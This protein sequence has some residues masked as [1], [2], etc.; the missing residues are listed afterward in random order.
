VLGGNLKIGK[1][2]TGVTNEI[3]VHRHQCHV[4]LASDPVGSTR[5]NEGDIVTR[6]SHVEKSEFKH[7]RASSDLILA[8]SRHLTCLG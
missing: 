3:V 1:Q 4:H 6:A 2:Q 5:H 8:L 7:T